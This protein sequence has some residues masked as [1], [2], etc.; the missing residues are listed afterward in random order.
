MPDPSEVLV[1]IPDLMGVTICPLGL[2]IDQLDQ[3]ASLEEATTNAGIDSVWGP[4]LR[5]PL[6][7]RVRRFNRDG[8]VAAL[9]APSER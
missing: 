1:L 3:G 5:G 4:E 9:W 2:L 7:E 6:F 8:D